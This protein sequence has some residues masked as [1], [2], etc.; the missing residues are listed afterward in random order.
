M[1]S[2]ELSDIPLGRRVV[3]RYRLPAGSELRFTDVIGELTA[4]DPVTV[5]TAEG[6]TVVIPDGTVVAVK[7]LGPRPIRTGEIRALELAAAAGW[8]GTAHEWIDG[9]LLHAGAGYTRRANSAVPLGAP[10]APA[11]LSHDTLHRIGRWYT[12]HGLPVQLRLPD[13]LAPPPPGWRTWGETV[14]LGLDIE[15]FVLPQGPPM[16]RVD[17]EP[18][19]EWLE[20]HRFAGEDAPAPLPPPPDPA[21]LTAVLDGEVGFATLGLPSPLAIGRGAITGSGDERTWVGLSCIAVAAPHR[22]HGLGALVCA[23]LIRWGHNRGATHAYVQVAAGNEAALSLYRELGFLD[24]HR[25]RY[26]APE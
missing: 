7:P 20:L 23:E 19:R 14:V 12:D 17:A 22:R 24:H 26:C 3:V 13:R 2:T 11:D 18:N 25:Y 8:P 16:V 21:V 1:T 10:G 4:I 9:W 5:R 15:N 6:A